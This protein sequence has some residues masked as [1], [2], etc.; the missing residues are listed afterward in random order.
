MLCIGSEDRPEDQITIIMPKPDWLKIRPPSGEKYLILKKTIEELKL[1]TVC[2]GARC[3]NIGEC[4][5]HGTATFMILGS[6]CT[7]NCRFCAV[8]KGNEGEPL[9]PSEPERVAQ[10]VK[11]MGL[12]YAVLTSVDRDDLPDGGAEHF[13]DCIRSIQKIDQNITVEALIPDFN[14][15]EISLRKIID[16][17]PDVAGHN[18]E[19]VD[20]FQIRIRDKRAGYILSLEVLRKL[21]Q[22]S[23]SSI[24]KSSLM[25]GLGET[26]AMIMKTMDD[27]RYAGVTVLTIGQYLRPSRNQIEVKEYVPPEKFSYYKKKA[28]E[29]GFISVNSNPLVRSS[30]MF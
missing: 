10:A 27:L 14:G 8:R 5:T 9:D 29:K 16:A 2:S 24:T 23:S 30:Y 25:L 11:R 22:M 13:A 18:I 6:I 17:H 26:E 12:K 3:P 4:W 20:E 7:R 1:N 15:D 19:T 21:K 28:L